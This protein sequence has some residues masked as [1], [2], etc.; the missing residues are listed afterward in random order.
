[1]KTKRQQVEATF[2][3]GVGPLPGVL[4]V[5]HRQ[6]EKSKPAPLVTSED[7]KVRTYVIPIDIV[8][9]QGADLGKGIRQILVSYRRR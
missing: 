2:N 5:A 7:G 9:L 4:Q 1:M 3:A 8:R 6:F